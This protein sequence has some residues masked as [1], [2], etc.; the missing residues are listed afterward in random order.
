MSKRFSLQTEY[1]EI[2]LKQIIADAVREILQQPLLQVVPQL[3]N[4]PPNFSSDKLLS[5]KDVSKLLNISLPTLAKLQNEGKIKAVII[6]GSYRYSKKH[7]EQFI[8]GTDKK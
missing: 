6:G 1:N 3:S 4:S 7:I 8:N 5:R 2:E